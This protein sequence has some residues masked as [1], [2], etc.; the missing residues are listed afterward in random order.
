MT[1]KR[2]SVFRDSVVLATAITVA[3]SGPAAFGAWLVRAP[4]S[5]V[6][7]PPSAAVSIAAQVSPGTQTPSVGASG[8]IPLGT[9]YVSGSVTIGEGSE[10][11]NVNGGSYQYQGLEPIVVGRE[12]RA[13]LRVKGAGS[14]FLCEGAAARMNG[15]ND[16]GLRIELGKGS[17]RLVFSGNRIPEIDAGA[18]A[19]VPTTSGRDA[20]RVAMDISI[21][22]SEVLVWP[23][24]EGA[25]GLTQDGEPSPWSVNVA[26]K[27]IAVLP[28]AQDGT[29]E[30]QYSALKVPA[31]VTPQI[32]RADVHPD[33]VEAGDYLC[34]LPDIAKLARVPEGR[35]SPALEDAIANTNATEIPDAL[36]PP[37][38]PELALVMPS[39]EEDTFDPN[40]LP[41]PAA[42]PQTVLATPARPVLNQ[43]GGALGSPN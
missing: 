4:E 15:A 14:V 34:K 11:R 6:R 43:G 38:S 12:S 20:E 18:N 24:N 28:G 37:G 2:V 7:L 17:M 29:V 25:K 39:A 5:L 8:P 41:E 23:L 42:G 27:M 30:D 3:I 31:L 33:A 36:L 35:E 13:V 22:N 40:L 10:R 1:G 32:L 9:L 19:I 16:A 26:D 21:G